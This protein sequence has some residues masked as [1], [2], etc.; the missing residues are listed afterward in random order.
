MCIFRV[1]PHLLTL[2]DCVP[3]Y[4]TVYSTNRALAVAAGEFLNAKVFSGGSQVP[5][6]EH[7]SDLVQFFIEVYF[8][9][10]N[11]YLL[12]YF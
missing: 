9:F 6:K 12:T 1:F 2:E 5:A 8:E 4:E 7:V 3:I 11:L 10:F